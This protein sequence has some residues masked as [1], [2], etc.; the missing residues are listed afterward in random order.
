MSESG[1]D[2]PA[3]TVAFQGEPGA[4]SEQATFELLGRNSVKA[5]G[6]ASFDDAFMAT[7]K[8]EVD[9]LMVPIENS[10]GGTIH[11]NCDLQL[12]YNFFII[13][14]HDF[15]VRHCLMALPGTKKED[16]TKIIS[17]PQALAQCD[18][19]IKR[20]GNRTSKGAPI[21]E[22]AYDTAG[23]A[24]MISDGKLAGVAAICSELAAD[25]YGLEIL[26]RGIEDDQN[27]FTRFLLL[28]CN[29]VRIPPGIPSKTSIVFSLENNA[30]ALFKALS[31][32]ALRDI[33]LTKIE[34]RPCKPDIVDR[35]ERQFW[36]MGGMLA[37][38]SRPG[39]FAPG[40]SGKRRK[41]D[42]EGMSNYRYIFYADFQARA[43]DPNAANALHHLQEIT[44]FF[45]VLGSYPRGGALVG[46]ENI[47]PR[48][49]PVV[50]STAAVGRK[51]KSASLASAHS[52][53]FWRRRW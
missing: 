5:I 9:L 42:G 11:A 41:L 32:F 40:E 13:A 39:V 36:S 38:G 29:P 44:S 6:H 26:D 51:K 14:E 30:G 23:S 46:L 34:S 10:L 37:A 33:D 12:Q 4:Y 27:N 28:R 18:S 50:S 8:G 48:V 25:Y 16:L 47:G 52:D 45:R 3:F 15:R 53:S 21:G 43:D 49:M 20:L 7:N 19:Y 35:M 2:A 31:V 22:A 17:H 24:K 1:G